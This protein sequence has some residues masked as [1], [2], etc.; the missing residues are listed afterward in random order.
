[1]NFRVFILS[2]LFVSCGT[3]YDY[4]LSKK[5]AQTEYVYS[6]NEIDGSG[7]GMLNDENADVELLKGIT[8]FQL[9]SERRR[10]YLNELAVDSVLTQISQSLLNDFRTSSFISS[11][12]WARKRRALKNILQ[13]QGHSNKLCSAHAFTVDILDLPFGDKF[14]FLMA[15]GES[16][17]HLYKGRK[18]TKK[19]REKDDFQ[20]PEPL[21]LIDGKIF[22]ERVLASLKGTAKYE[23]YSKEFSTIGISFKLDHRSMNCRKRPRV[24]GIIIF[25]G[26]RTQKVKIHPKIKEYEDKQSDSNQTP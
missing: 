17:I 7:V 22:S 24:L 20:E 5:I 12:S 19:E 26:K 21:T 16:H 25:G 8:L 6:D 1:M 3:T 9:N 15:A 18:P 4:R 13:I 10:K 11:D 14:H 23:V 2:I